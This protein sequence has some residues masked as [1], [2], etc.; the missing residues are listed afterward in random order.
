MKNSAKSPPKLTIRQKRVLEFS[1]FDVTGLIGEPF[2]QSWNDLV[3]FFS[4]SQ[5]DLVCVG[6]RPSR[7]SRATT[8][9]VL[10]GM[11]GIM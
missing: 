4:R 8:E 1:A 7:L 10:E 9:E 11:A 2:G 3:V 5:S 6:L